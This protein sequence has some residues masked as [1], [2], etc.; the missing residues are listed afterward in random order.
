MS[1]GLTAAASGAILLRGGTLL[2]HGD[3]D[4]VEPL[5][6]TDILVRNN[7]IAKIGKSIAAP[8]DAELVD[9]RG[10][11]ITPGFVDTHH[12]LWQTQLKGCHADQ[13][14]FDYI[15]TGFWQS[16]VYTPKDMFWGQLGGALEAIASGTTFVLDH[17]HG[18]QSNDHARQAL[19]ATIA[20][21]IRSI[22]AYSHAPYFTKWDAKSCELSRDIMPESSMAHIF[23]LAQQQPFGNGR[24]HI[25]FGFDYW[26]L[27]KEAVVGIFSQL[28]GAGI[29]LFT[30]HY[31]KNPTFG[32]HPLIHTLAAYNLIKT[33]SDILLSHATGLDEHEKAKLA[34]TQVPVSSTPDTEAQMG[35]GWPLAF[36]PGIN[37]TLGVDCH[38]NNTSSIL[39]LAR[40]ALQLARQRNTVKEMKGGDGAPQR[41]DLRPTGSTEDAFNAATIR[42]ARA[43]L[44]GNEIGSIKEGKL[45]DLVI[46]DALGSVGM[47]CVSE[48]DPL[49]AVVRHSDSRD[50][51]A[52]MIDGVWRKR[53]GRLC[54]VTV[55]ETGASLAWPAIRQN[56]LASQRDIQG[57]QK[58]LNVDKAKEAL[59][60]MFQIDKS[61][62]VK[63]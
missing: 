27:P 1:R 41:M 30:S 47:S 4:H 9:C 50:I 57:R 24:V 23:E 31:A 60:A 18:N 5:R 52:V 20:S 56:L 8:V 2:Y 51:E 25:G 32:N 7:R 10:K 40:T 48:S 63:S 42:G 26:F 46:F 35:F 17:A 53:D 29:K 43:V 11:I 49:T 37:Y 6:D 13:S 15:P 3:Q 44:L 39:S 61:K 34:E 54:L 14:V 45:A 62:L 59:V 19:S 33:P 21:G 16:Y 22:F 55:E 36:T 28:R 38:T 12:H 58:N